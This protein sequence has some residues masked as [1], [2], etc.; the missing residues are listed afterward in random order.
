VPWYY[1]GGGIKLSY[2][3]TD[4]RFSFGRPASS[5]RTLANAAAELNELG[6]MRKR[7]RLWAQALAKATERNAGEA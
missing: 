7:G 4:L 5:S 2:K 6:A 3:G 1:F